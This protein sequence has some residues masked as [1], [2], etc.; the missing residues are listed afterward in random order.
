[1]PLLRGLALEE[2]LL[3]PGKVD[4]MAANTLAL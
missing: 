1:M 2:A 3:G 4:I